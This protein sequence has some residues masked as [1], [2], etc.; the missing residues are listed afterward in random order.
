[1]PMVDQDIESGLHTEA[2]QALALALEA[3]ADDAVVSV[4]SGRST[5]YAYRDGR[6]EKVQ[7]S[8]SRMVGLQ[9]YVDGRYSGH[10]SNDLRPS[11]LRPFLRDAVALTRALEAL[12]PK[13]R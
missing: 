4:S 6:I 7:E 12:K 11:V 10:Q 2:E 5:E 3:G 1:M 9:L 13:V 8:M